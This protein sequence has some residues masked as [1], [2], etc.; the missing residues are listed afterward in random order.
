MMYHIHT[1]H[2]GIQRRGN[3]EIV[4]IEASLHTLERAGVRFVFTDRHA[5]LST[6]RFYNS[7]EK[8][9][10]IDWP[11]LQRRDFRLDPDDQNKGHRYQAEALVHKFLPIEILD[12]LVCSSAAVESQLRE[13]VSQRGLTLPVAARPNW[14]FR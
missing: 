1:G 3:D 9:D 6:A 10:Q 7:L 4:I 8:L 11:L 13:L 5:Y 14:Y 2:Y 12:G